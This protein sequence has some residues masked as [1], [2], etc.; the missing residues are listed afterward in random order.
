M[1][2]AS[3]RS[4]AI[5]RVFSNSAATPAPDPTFISNPS[6][7]S[8]WIGVTTVPSVSVRSRPPLVSKTPAAFSCPFAV[9]TMSKSATRSS[10]ARADKRRQSQRLLAMAF[11]VGEPSDRR[12]PAA[13][14]RILHL[15]AHLVHAGDDAGA[16]VGRGLEP[17]GHRQIRL[18]RP[19]RRRRFARRPHRALVRVDRLDR[20]MA[21]ARVLAVPRGDERGHLLQ[22]LHRGRRPFAR[23]RR[24]RT[25]DEEQRRPADRHR[26]QRAE[27]ASGDG[28]ERTEERAVETVEGNRS[29]HDH[30]SRERHGAD[31]RSS[32]RRADAA[33]RSA[34]PIDDLA[35]PTNI[36]PGVPEFNAEQR[37]P[38]GSSTSKRPEI[39]NWHDFGC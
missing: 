14:R 11:V 34:R 19:H 30:A 37:R 21:C 4:R 38:G 25:R 23:H 8:G 33:E 27:H 32:P 15:T 16:R 17:T 39:L 29:A 1:S 3:M 18:C 22:P 7:P 2:S 6:I 13:H 10:P 20:E 24:G 35:T 26:D 12:R 28:F 5:I 9:M 36:C 31:G